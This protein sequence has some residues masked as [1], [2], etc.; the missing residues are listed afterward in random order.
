M[1]SCFF[2]G[3]RESVERLLPQLIAL[4]ERLIEEEQVTFFYVGGYGGFDR[5]AASAVK[6]AKRKYSEVTL[7]M[8]AKQ[9]AMFDALKGLTEAIAEKEKQYCRK[10]ELSES[11]IAE[12]NDQLVTLN[13]GDVISVNYYCNY[14]KQYRKITG[15][16]MKIDSFWKEVQIEKRLL[17]FLKLKALP[18]NYS[19]AYT[20]QVT[21]DTIVDSSFIQ[22]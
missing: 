6:V 9:F 19:D 15:T 16:I 21:Q 10:K 17:V 5:V 7:R 4:V 22:M 18:V 2:I 20:I 14:S 13:E 3:H 11:E 1:K 8:R 12:I